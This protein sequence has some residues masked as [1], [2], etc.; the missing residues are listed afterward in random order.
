MIVR[1]R[2]DQS[3][4]SCSQTLFSRV[5]VVAERPGQSGPR[6][7]ARAS[8]KSPVLIPLRYRYGISSSMLLVFRRYG[9]SNFE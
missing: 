2:A 1:E 7:A 3:R 5:M 9:G 6:I 4:Y 8:W